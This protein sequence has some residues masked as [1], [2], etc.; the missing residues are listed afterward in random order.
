MRVIYT[1]H[2]EFR[3][4][5]RD[6]PHGL[7]RQIVEDAEGHYYDN[8]TKHYVAVRKVEFEGRLREMAVS[9]DRLE[10][11]IEVVTIHPMKAYQKHS[12]VRT[13]RWVKV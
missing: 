1:S 2:L 13:G 3:L 12:R 8:L 11:R 6:I 7:P 4:K 9:Y 5:I 10:D